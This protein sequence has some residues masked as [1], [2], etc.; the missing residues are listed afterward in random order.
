MNACFGFDSS[1]FFFLFIFF[2]FNSSLLCCYFSLARVEF[3]H[4]TH[5]IYGIHIKLKN[6]KLDMIPITIIIFKCTWC[7]IQCAM[8]EE[9]E[10]CRHQLKWC[11]VFG[12]SNQISRYDRN[13]V[14]AVFLNFGI[15]FSSVYKFIHCCCFY[16]RLYLIMRLSILNA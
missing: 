6:H 8:A 15:F 2:S 10:I 13:F 16:A 11:L 12:R 3:T 1:Q 4:C 7:W 9:I 5:V 14:V